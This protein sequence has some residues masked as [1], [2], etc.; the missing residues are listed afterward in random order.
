MFKS[1]YQNSKSNTVI[2]LSIH[3]SCGTVAVKTLL[4]FIHVFSVPFS[5]SILLIGYKE[6]HVAC[7]IPASNTGVFQ[8]SFVGA[9]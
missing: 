5:A 1:T 9:D 4:H 6:V 2:V 8:K 7:N 3:G